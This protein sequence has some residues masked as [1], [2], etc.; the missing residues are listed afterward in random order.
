LEWVYALEGDIERDDVLQAGELESVI[1]G[2]QGFQFVLY[3]FGR[4][5]G[6]SPDLV[7]QALEIAYD[8]PALGRIQPTKTPGSVGSACRSSS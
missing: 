5:R 3:F 8:E 2:E 4:R 1:P 7:W 6:A